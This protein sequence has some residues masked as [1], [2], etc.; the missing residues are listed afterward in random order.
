M[1][2]RPAPPIYEFAEFRLDAQRRVLSSRVDGQP[3]QVTSKA[4]D[5]LLYF[6]ERAGQLLDK[7]TLMD[8][9]WPN[10]VVEE[11]NL[12]QTI[13]TLRRVL[14]ERPDEH[15][16]IVTVPGRGYRF[17]AQVTAT[18]VDELQVSAA[19]EP[20][21]PIVVPPAADG[22]RC[23]VRQ[24]SLWRLWRSFCSAGLRLSCAAT[25]APHRCHRSPCC[26]SWI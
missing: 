19:T 14:G 22:L 16:Y 2:P 17:V 9:L 21:S 24:L 26:R 18:A 7:R 23:S 11:S 1:N 20:T 4:F 6:V 13:Y 5:A 25:R 10:V 12:T 8:A 3:L 15:R